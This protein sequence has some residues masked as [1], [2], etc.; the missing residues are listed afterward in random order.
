MNPFVNPEKRSVL[1][2]A[3]CKDLADVLRLPTRE[4]GDPV[5][6][7]IRLMLLRAEGARATE[8][9]IEA[10][11]VHEAECIITQRINGRFHHVSTIQARFRSGV[12]GELLRMA[13][14]PQSQF[15][16]TGIA[17]LELKRRQLKW[18]LQIDGADTDC[19]LMQ[20]DE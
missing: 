17:T 14:L 10:P 7:F 9:L 12:V 5:Q 3:G 4:A 13:G 2:P 1:L 15:P 20:S 8:I 11:M 19:R 18:K 16:A 6:V